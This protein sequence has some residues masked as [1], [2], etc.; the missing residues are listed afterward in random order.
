MTCW[1]SIRAVVRHLT[2]HKCKSASGELLSRPRY[3]GQTH[4]RAVHGDQ[5]GHRGER[6]DQANR[7]HDGDSHYPCAH[8]H[9]LYVA[10]SLP[11]GA[12]IFFRRPNVTWI[13]NAQNF[14]ELGPRKIGGDDYGKLAGIISIGDVVKH[15]LEDLECE[16]NV[17][18]DAY[19]ATHSTP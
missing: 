9:P 1:T 13:T 7:D 3:S 6:P 2:W 10:L 16:T 12:R 17:L 4:F 11:I 19:M 15:R 18:R 14:L 5:V 8:L